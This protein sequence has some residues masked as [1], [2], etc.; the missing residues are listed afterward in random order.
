MVSSNKEP[1]LSSILLSSVDVSTIL[2]SVTDLVVVEVCWV[3]A[4]VVAGLA[5]TSSSLNTVSIDSTNDSASDLFSS[6]S[7][8]S[9]LLLCSWLS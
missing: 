5:I 6:D 3:V 1:D 2:A 7:S 9:S 8:V 4:G